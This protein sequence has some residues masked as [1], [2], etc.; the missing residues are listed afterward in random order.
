MRHIGALALSAAAI[1]TAG[2]VSAEAFDRY[3]DGG[4]GVGF[5]DGIDFFGQTVGYDLAGAGLAVSG[6][7][8]RYSDGYPYYGSTYGYNTYAA[9]T[10]YYYARQPAYIYASS[11]YAMNGTA[12]PSRYLVVTGRSAAIGGFGRYCSTPIKS[13]MLYEPSMMGNGCSCK[14]QGGRSH[15]SVTP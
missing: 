15:G 5:F 12:M 2:T 6:A 1:I 4:L 3:R 11:G 9:P 14:V 13:C 8:Y 7:G 10:Y